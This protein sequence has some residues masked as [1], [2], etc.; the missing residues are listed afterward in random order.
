MSG[1][2]FTV[3]A[4]RAGRIGS[5]AGWPVNVNLARYHGRVCGVYVRV[6]ST[7]LVAGWFR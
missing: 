2:V 7:A 1:S 5:R 3:R 6:G 4:P